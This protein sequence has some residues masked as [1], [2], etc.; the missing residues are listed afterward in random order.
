MLLCRRQTLV[1]GLLC[2]TGILSLIKTIKQS[3]I[4]ILLYLKDLDLVSYKISSFTQFKTSLKTFERGLRDVMKDNLKVVFTTCGRLSSIKV[5]F[6][7]YFKSF[8]SDKTLKPWHSSITW[9]PVEA[10]YHYRD[11]GYFKSCM[12][13]P[14][15][16]SDC[17]LSFLKVFFMVSISTVTI[18]LLQGLSC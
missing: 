10:S 18:V 11:A 9:E 5:G 13:G 3:W 1:E 2:K 15:A 7:G 14:W 17:F 4:W 16:C 8:A 6:E 12:S